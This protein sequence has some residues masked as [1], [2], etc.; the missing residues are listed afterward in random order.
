MRT[1]LDLPESLFRRLKSRAA[2]EGL[3]LKDLIARYVAAGLESAQ[4]GQV[5][6][7]G[8]EAPR[9]VTAWDLIK[10]GCGMFDS[11]HT[12]LATHPKHMEGFG[13]D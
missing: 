4:P 7:A 8:L 9:I 12:D 6:E 1:T 10:D 5:S 3:P 2:L 13:R 11:G